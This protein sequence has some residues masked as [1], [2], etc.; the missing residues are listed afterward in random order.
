[1][2]N[3]QKGLSLIGVLVAI[4]ITSTG[5][6][7]VLNLANISLKGSQVGKMRLIA[8]GLVQEGIEIVRDIRR[9]NADWIDW[10]W[11]GANGAIATSSS[12]SYLVQYNN[13]NLISFSEAP[14]KINTDGFYQYDFGNDTVFYRKV[15]LTKNSFQEV[16]VVVEV[17]WRLKGQW[18][19]LT[20]EDRLWNWK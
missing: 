19:Y 1:V 7:A 12:Q 11:Y 13:A 9:S 20:I 18:H 6:V 15:T 3:H 10:E 17:K 8:S 16:K 14:L 2:P 4:L 5:L